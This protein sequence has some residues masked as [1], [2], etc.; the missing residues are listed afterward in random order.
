MIHKRLKSGLYKFFGEYFFVEM[1]ADRLKKAIDV[2]F[3]RLDNIKSND[4]IE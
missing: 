1:G 4:D 2:S 3:P